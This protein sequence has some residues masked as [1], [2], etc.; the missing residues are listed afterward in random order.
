MNDN[1]LQMSLNQGKHFKKKFSKI[2]KGKPI[3][4]GFVSLEQEEVIRPSNQGFV[5][6]FKNMQENTNLTTNMNQTNLNDLEQ[7]KLKYNELLQQYTAMQQKISNSSLGSIN[8]L[9]S[10]NP[11][12]NKTVR[13]NNGPWCYVTNQGVAGWI[14]G[15][16]ILYSTTAPTQPIDINLPWLDSYNTPGTTIPTNPP[17]ISG[18]PIQMKQSLGNEGS[19]VY[20]SKLVNNPSSDY[21]GCYNDF[22]AETLISVVPVMNSS[23]I[24]NGFQSHSSSVYG[25]NSAYGHWAAFDGNPNTF[26]L[27][28]DG[29]YNGSNGIYK[30]PNGVSVNG[31]GFVRGEHLQ[32]NMPNV[33]TPSQQNTIVTQYSIA[34]RLDFGLT[35]RSPNSWYVLGWKDNIW[36]AVDRQQNQNFRSGDA[37]TYNVA[38]PGSYG[39][40]ILL[41]DKVGNDDD[42]SG[43]RTIVQVAEWKLFTSSV[44]TR[45]DNQRAMIWNPSVIGYTTLDKCQ[46]YA[47]ENGYKYFGLQNVQ[48]DGSAAC[49][50]SNDVDKSKMY[51]DASVQRTAIPL[52]SSNTSSGQSNYAQLVGTGQIQIVDTIRNAV[53]SF[54][55]DGVKGCESWGT[56]TVQSATYGGNCNG[57]SIGNV[58]DKVD[59]MGCNWVESCSI[60]IS[61]S[62][63]GDPAIGCGKNFDVAYSCGSTKFS[64]HLEG[65]ANGQTLILDD[66]KKYMKDNCTFFLFLHDEGEMCIYRGPDNSQTGEKVWSSNTKGQQKVANPDWVASKGKY[67]RDYLRQGEGLGPDEWIGSGSGFIKLMMQKDGNLVLY[68]SETK[69][70][71]K[72]INDKTYGGAGINAIYQLNNTGNK[73]TLGK[74][75]YINSDSKLMLYPDSML[76]S[77]N[78]Y[79]NNYQIF[80]DLDSGGYDI[81]AIDVNNQS[82][83]QT[84]CNNNKEC[85]SYQYYTPWKRCFLK[86]KDSYPKT[87]TNLPGGIFGTKIP[88]VK[89]SGSK[90]CSNKIVNVDTVQFDNYIKGSPMTP[91]TQCNAPIVG[92][93]DRL[94]FDNIKSQLITLGNDIVSNTEKLYSEDNNIFAKLNMNEEQFKKNIENYKQTNIKIQKELNLQDN[95]IEGMQN[96]NDINGMLNDSDLRVLQENY[97]YIMWSIVAIGLLT[98]TINTLKK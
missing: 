20:A 68:T 61:V 82:E 80:R 60:P 76:E 62:T 25:N 33:N 26:W 23:T 94:A 85:K 95:N 88:E 83:C 66:C 19:N 64:K 35:S 40:Y 38:T 45:S 18:P 81:T 73:N 28:D 97:S 30:G 70:S 91:T 41:T 9:A 78:N 10:N 44:Y 79:Q 98:I 67:G 50:V 12:L 74:V 32:I 43:I 71:C 93:Q 84:A 8:R 92:D 90:T 46:D 77:T 17:L 89:L 31:V 52:W 27:S 5:P 37:K 15:F 36:Y 16:D 4:E 59:K 86:N 39:A 63:F 2:K 69:S 96:L 72:V 24:V 54:A 14:H 6:V 21:V 47:V 51:G 49:L 42:T 22:P 87:L 75:G 56:L 11:Y 53:V 55:N 29:V 58:T 34:P 57:V 7:A 13:F 1:L 48:S 65:E 3:K